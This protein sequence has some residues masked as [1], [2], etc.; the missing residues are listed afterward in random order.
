MNDTQAGRVLIN[1]WVSALLMLLFMTLF[2]FYIFEWSL[3]ASVFVGLLTTGVWVGNELY[4]WDP[5]A[6]EEP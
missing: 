3:I 6:V 5:E 4:T 1:W 2:T